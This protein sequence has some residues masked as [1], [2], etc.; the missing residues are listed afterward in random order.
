TIEQWYGTRIVAAGAGFLYNNEMGDFNAWPGRTDSTGLIGTKPNLIQPG[1]RMLSSMT[2]TIV[3]RDGK[4]ILVTGSPGGRTIINT[5][6]QTILNV[7]EFD[8]NVYDAVNAPRFHHQWLPD[9]IRIEKWGTTKDSIELLEQMGHKIE[10]R[11]T[12]GR[13]MAIMID[14]ETG[15]RTG[16]ADPRSPNRGAVGY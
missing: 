3:A 16:A 4:T 9:V 1:K 12:I 11:G 5:V 14:S 15:Y 10:W 2:P 7:V 13:A 6:L 8:M